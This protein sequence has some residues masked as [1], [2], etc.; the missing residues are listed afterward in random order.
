MSN[1][2]I[3]KVIVMKFYIQKVKGQLHCD[4]MMVCRNTLLAI[5]KHYN[6]GSKEETVTIFY[7]CS[8]TELVTLI[9]GTHLETVIVLQEDPKVLCILLKPLRS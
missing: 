7:I 2:I 9:L 8:Y 1:G 3:D 5:I 6:S 4:I